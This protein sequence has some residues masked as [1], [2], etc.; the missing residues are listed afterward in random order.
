[1]ATPMRHGPS[2]Q[3]RTPSQVP[4]AAPTPP[5]STPFS[6]S[7]TQ[8]AFSPAQGSKT[9]PQAFRK[10][11]ANS[12]TLKGL[13]DGAGPVNFDS[14][15]AA[16]A[17][18]AL[19]IHDLGLDNLSMGTMGMGMGMGMGR[20]DDDDR[21]RRMDIIIAMIKA[22]GKGRVSNEGLERLAQTNGLECMWEDNIAGGPKS[23]NLFIAG[24]GLAIEITITNHHV[25]NVQVTYPECADTT[26]EHVG[27]AAD[28]LLRDLKLEPGE[29]ALTKTLEKFT[30]N[31]ERI[32]ILDKL[33]VLPT[34]NCYDAIDGIYQSL[35][36][37]HDWDVAKLKEDP[38]MQGRSEDYIKL[39]ALYRRHGC[40]QMHARDRIGLSLDYWK[41]AKRLPGTTIE[42]DEK[43]GVKTWGILIECAAKN[44]NMVFLPIRVSKSWIAEEIE[45]TATAEEQLM[46]PVAGPILNWLEPENTLLPSGAGSKPEGGISS[47]PRLPEVVFMATF[48]P[49]LIVS[50]GVAAQIYNT[51]GIQAPHGS[52]V[53]FD[54]LIFPVVAGTPYDPTESRIVTHEQPVMLSETARSTRKLRIHQNTLNTDRAVYGE[55]LTKV[56]FHHPRQLVEMLPVL[57][58]YAFLQSLL[59]NSFE[60]NE[61]PEHKP[62]GAVDNRTSTANDDFAAFM[63]GADK[64]MTVNSSAGDESFPVNIAMTAHPVP[65]LRIS[66]PFK[67]KTANI[68]LEIQLGGRVHIISDNIFEADVEGIQ[69]GADPHSWHGPGK[70][71]N[72]EQWADQLEIVEHI[73]K[74]IERIKYKFNDQ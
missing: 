71:Y 36:K 51:A 50:S 25:E 66:F 52:S 73:G 60:K 14:P 6:N 72:A 16:A 54:A 12:H 57:R 43:E 8:A 27:K 67:G 61:H 7:Q 62:A 23:K 1:M 44:N 13:S 68:T 74:W 22:A 48:D 46:Q 65:N 37:L 53:T 55:V 10:S 70:R 38:K 63:G 42:S 26:R 21:K 41:E 30:P 69:E 32:S 15:S 18:G 3:G 2:Q 47:D 20:P 29:W 58:Q 39:A 9:S 28:I 17:L 19:G 64:S 24:S 31:L 11:P 35:L 40:P 5:V 4:G 33:S 49:P 45:K 56:P 34:L 59:A